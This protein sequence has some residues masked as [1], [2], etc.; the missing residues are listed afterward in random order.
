MG[1][2]VVYKSLAKEGEHLLDLQEI[3]ARELK[4]LKLF[5]KL[6]R[7]KGL[8]YYMA[9][10]TLLG[11]V[12]HGGFI[13]WDDDIDLLMPRPDYD[14]L[15]EIVRTQPLMPEY[16]FHSPELSNL[17]DPF[18][19]IFDLSTRVDKDFQK[20]PFDRYLWIDIFPMD[21]LPESMREVEK[22]YQKVHKLR[23]LLKFMKAKEGTGSSPIRA[24]IKPI[25]KPFALLIF[26]KKRTV[27]KIEHIA[28]KYSFEESHYVGGVV[29]GYGPQERMEREKYVE[30][31][32]MMFEDCLS[33]APGSYDYDLKSL[34]GDYMQLRP[35]EKRKVHFMRI[36]GK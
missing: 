20:D 23:K 10:G 2:P 5:D 1:K 3:H 26:G 19:K 12:R 24:V 33:F 27:N 25:L 7:E 9:G 13:P 6:C 8:R 22:I 31:V 34:F 16:E 11:A 21:G 36:Y 14:R 15:Q 28:K 29:F 17:Y 4:M 32:P 30:Q 35:E 18:C